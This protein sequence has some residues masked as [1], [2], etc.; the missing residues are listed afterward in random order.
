MA[1]YT[2]KTRHMAISTPLGEDKLL[3]VRFRAVE[4][5][6]RLFEFEA[7]C[8]SEDKQIDF[9]KLVG[10][11]V[12]VRVEQTGVYKAAGLEP[13]R[14]FNGFVSRVA[15]TGYW[16][17]LGRYRLSIVPQM[18]LLTRASNCRI[19]QKTSVPDLVE[20]I[21][22][23]NGMEKPERG[24]SGS[25][26]KR[27]YVVQYRETD[28]NFISRLLE[29]EGIYYFFKHENGKH[30][31]VLADSA[32]ASKDTPGYEKIKF[33][34]GDHDKSRGEVIQELI[35]EQE[36]QPGEY[37]VNDFDFTKVNTALLAKAK[38][39]REHEQSKFAMYDYPGEYD[40]QPGGES[41]AKVRLEEL[42]VGHEVI[43]G[44]SDARGILVGG[45]MKI[46]EH[47]PLSE[48]Q[49]LVTGAV[50]QAE[51]DEY[52]SQGSS[53]GGA[54]NFSVA[55]TAMRTELGNFRPARITPRPIIAGPQTAI[56][57]GKT[58]LEIDTDEWG[59][60][61]LQFHWDRYS[62]AD[63]NSSCWVRV[64]QA[65]AGKKWGWMS[66]PRIGQEVV[67]EF[68]EGDP[69]RPLVTGRVY[70]NEN[71]PPYD[72]KAMPTITT[73][74]SSTSKGG[75]G[76]NELRFEDKKDEEQIFIHAQKNLDI[77]VKN[78]RFETIEDDRHLHVKN[79]KYEK[80]DADSH[81]TVGGSVFVKIDTD[82]HENVLKKEAREIGESKSLKVTGDVIEEFMKNQ[83]TVVK[84]NH[85][86]KADNIVIEGLSNVTVKVGQSYIAIEAG[87]IKI[88]TT[89]NIEL[90]ST[91]D[92]KIKAT[93][94]FKAEATANAEI[95]GTAGAKLES[96]AMCDVKGLQASLKGDAMVTVKGGVTMVG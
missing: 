61:K 33:D 96:T 15:Q 53:G 23:D 11:N 18:W 52:G 90:E 12:T 37:A 21:L 54:R 74:K 73:F 1:K 4:Q 24:L 2:Q 69:D 64:S 58:G 30:T 63:E 16:G 6:G 50:V 72:P 59:R 67:V 92:T 88:G 81:V 43:R 91:G 79:K 42:Q 70:N 29:E 65:W 19:F 10:Q 40:Q 26:E 36:I 3:L 14:Y 32:A 17:A 41:L 8:Q 20:K 56:V 83:S 68:L 47:D 9:N 25:Y 80:V 13:H 38:V 48:K 35:A 82:L 76:F 62:K 22:T 34:P 85:Y 87:G 93:G 55:F 45:T 66:I 75:S 89:G 57:V 44:R 5:L 60:V 78:D 49:L 86:L 51:T 46:M 28:F 7:E 84:S 95:K 27:E 39:S 31:M 71:P 77:R 94:N